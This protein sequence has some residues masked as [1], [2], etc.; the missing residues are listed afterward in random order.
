MVSQEI[1][2]GGGGEGEFHCIVGCKFGYVTC[3]LFLDVVH[4]G[5]V[6]N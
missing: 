4:A 3:V 2:G 6:Y 1:G 5:G